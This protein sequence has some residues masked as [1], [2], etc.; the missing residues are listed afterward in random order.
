MCKCNG[1][2]D[3]TGE[4]VGNAEDLGVLAAT[5]RPRRE[6]AGNGSFEEAEDDEDDLCPEE[7]SLVGVV[8]IIATCEGNRQEFLH[9]SV[10][11]IYVAQAKI[12][13]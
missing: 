3:A 13:N 4:R 1:Q 5:S 11:I 12:Q 7:Q 8:V 9:L 10:K 6:H 2:E